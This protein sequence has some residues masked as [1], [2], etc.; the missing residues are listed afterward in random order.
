V[1]TTASDAGG[2]AARGHPRSDGPVWSAAVPPHPTSL[3]RAA[4]D[5]SAPD[6]GALYRYGKEHVIELVQGLRTDQ[7]VA[8]V[9]GCPGW[10][11]HCVVSH[12]A[13]ISADAIGGRLAGIPSEDQ[14]ARQVDERRHVPTSVVLRE[15]E[16]CAS[17]FELVLSRLPNAPLPAAVDVSVHEQD[18]RGAVGLPGHRDNPVIELAV[19]RLLGNWFQALTLNGHALPSVFTSDGD[20]IGGD[21]DSTVGW[22]TTVFEVFRTAFGRRSMAQFARHFEGAEPTTYLPL[23]LAFS[24]SSDDIVE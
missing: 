23:L 14:T 9:P 11:V 6:V 19:E 4:L 20:L 7:L 2:W 24:V 22:T 5:R 17:Q 21:P 18:I 3:S 15:W 1:D 16:R 13:G 8:P 10:T 12:L